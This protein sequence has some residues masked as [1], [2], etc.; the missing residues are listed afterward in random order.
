[1]QMRRR[2][3]L[4]LCVV[5]S[6]VALTGLQGSN[7]QGFAV[8]S[9]HRSEGVWESGEHAWLARPMLGGQRLQRVRIAPRTMRNFWGHGVHDKLHLSL[10]AAHAPWR[11]QLGELLESSHVMGCVVALIVID[12]LIT[13]FVSVVEHT[14]V[15][16]PKLNEKMERLV[17]R[18]KFLAI[19][20]LV[21]FAI[22]QLGHF[23]AFGKFFFMKPLFVL[24]S[25]VVLVNLWLEISEMREAK[26]SGTEETQTTRTKTITKRAARAAMSLRLWKLAALS[27]DMFYAGFLERSIHKHATEHTSAYIKAL[28]F[29]IQKAGLPLP[30]V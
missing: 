27:F 16:N 13:F 11:V 4:G 20:I 7:T 25:L 14:D 24:D 19:A 9:R 5:A 10:D 1:M 2:G 30:R 8:S 29:V 21:T 26:K 28:E 15:I 6:C 3:S 12:L 18:S 23:L 17:K 22:E